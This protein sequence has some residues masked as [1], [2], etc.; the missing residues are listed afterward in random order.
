MKWTFVPQTC[1][2]F[3]KNYF[4]ESGQHKTIKQNKTGKAMLRST[5]RSKISYRYMDISK[6]HADQTKSVPTIS[7]QGN[8][9]WI[10][11]IK[12]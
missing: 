10:I 3:K 7:K 6:S 8:K 11:D 12:E 1:Q 4:L 9:P 2:K 5:I